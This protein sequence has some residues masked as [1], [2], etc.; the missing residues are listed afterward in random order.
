MGSRSEKTWLYPP[1]LNHQQQRPPVSSSTP[2]VDLV[3]V[4]D[5]AAV[6]QGSA[7]PAISS[8]TNSDIHISEEENSKKGAR[9]RTRTSKKAPTTLFNTD[10][11]NF[12]AMVQQFTGLSAASFVHGNQGGSSLSFG[13]EVRPDHRQ[14]SPSALSDM[15]HQQKETG[16]SAVSGGRPRPA[17]SYGYWG[18]R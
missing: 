6:L 12:R 8:G 1:S 14:I 2:T 10:V 7:G 17:N 5:A 18:L 3:S 15:T 13:H 4:A 16:T 9:K 11:H